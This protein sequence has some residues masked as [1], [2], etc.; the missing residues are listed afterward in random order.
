[1]A[2]W[3]QVVCWFEGS[4]STSLMPQC[5]MLRRGGGGGFNNP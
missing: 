1:M 3:L 4:S 2:R 5:R